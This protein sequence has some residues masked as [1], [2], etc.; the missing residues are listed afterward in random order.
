MSV[1]NKRQ[2]KR[3]CQISGVE[4]APKYRRILERYEHRADALFEA[5]IAY[6]TE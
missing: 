2:V 6:A 5:G 4:I 1:T 3:I